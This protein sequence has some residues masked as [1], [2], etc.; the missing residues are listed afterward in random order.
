[1][2]AI[3]LWKFQTWTQHLQL[4]EGIQF[5][6]TESTSWDIPIQTHM[7]HSYRLCWKSAMISTEPVRCFIMEY[8]LVH[9]TCFCCTSILCDELLIVYLYYT[10]VGSMCRWLV[11]CMADM[12][13]TILT[14]VCWQLTSTTPS[15]TRQWRGRFSR[16]YSTDWP[17]IKL[18]CWKI[19]YLSLIGRKHSKS[20]CN[21]LQA[22][23]KFYSSHCLGCVLLKD[24]VSSSVSTC[25]HSAI[26]S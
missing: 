23:A 8:T 19:E 5:F 12:L 3:V 22:L 1:M 20:R 16:M 6:K 11:L 9:N 21:A 26:L 4:D 14:D 10:H 18:Y 15:T 17:S 7:G 25:L 13:L 24:I 2:T